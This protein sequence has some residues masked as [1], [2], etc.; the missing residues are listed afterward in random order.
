[1]DLDGLDAFFAVVQHGS[2][3]AAARALGVEPSATSR[4]VAKLEADLGVALLYRTTRQVKLTEAGRELLDQGGPALLRLREAAEEVRSADAALRGLIRLSV[5]GA[6]GRRRIAPR[7]FGFL[8]RNPEVS[9]DLRV[10]DARLDLLAEGIDLALRVGVP[11]EPNFTR[12]LLGSSPQ[13]FYAAAQT[14]C[15]A[16]LP[17]R[18][19]DLAQRRLILRREGG[20][21]LAPPGAAAAPLICDD[22]ETVARAVCAGLG[23]G[24]LPVWLAEEL[25]ELIRLPIQSPIP[26]AQIFAVLPGGRRP[27]RRVR[28]L[29]DWLVLE[30]TP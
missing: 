28:A 13:A 14:L 25:P 30:P 26:P 8:E 11:R 22:V 15:G 3:T 18:M 19:E 27:P 2:F 20:Q 12:R 7:L 16:P 24:L 6:F 21:V 10:S 23:V 9:I 1:M 17:A 29:L 5:P 4:R